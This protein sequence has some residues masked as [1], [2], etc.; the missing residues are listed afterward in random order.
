MARAFVTVENGAESHQG[1]LTYSKGWKMP[2][3][4]KQMC[5]PWTLDTW[6]VME[7]WSQSRANCKW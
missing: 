1:G 2:I 7:A 5:V 3:W 6:L 4:Y